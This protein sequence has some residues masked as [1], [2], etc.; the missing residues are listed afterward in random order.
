MFPSYRYFSTGNMI[1]PVGKYLEKLVH[2]VRNYYPDIEVQKVKTDIDH[3]HMIVIIPPKYGI[4]EV[5]RIIN[6]NTG[7]RLREKF[8]YLDKVY[9]GV[10]RYLFDWLFCIDSRDR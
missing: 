9:W 7:K 10:K 1:W 4:S 6:V 2:Q 8:K 5:V 3:M